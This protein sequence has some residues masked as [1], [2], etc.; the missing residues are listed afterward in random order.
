MNETV[1]HI[2]TR[3]FI[4][5]EYLSDIIQILLYFYS[6]TLKSNDLGTQIQT[7]FIPGIPGV[8]GKNYDF[9]I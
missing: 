3:I 1:N 4:L 5:G 7:R 2:S 8:P 6:D 9:N